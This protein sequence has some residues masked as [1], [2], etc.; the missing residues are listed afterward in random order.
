MPHLREASKALGRVNTLAAELKDPFI[1]SRILTWREAVSSSAIEGTNSTLDELLS[2][3][4]R[5]LEDVQAVTDATAQVR[6]YARL[7]ET[8]IPH[9]AD[10]GPEVFTV[11]LIR[12]LH[13]NVM[14]SDSAYQDEPGVL[15]KNVVWIGG[16]GNE[17]A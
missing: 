2:V 8:R 15:R 14:A 1:V 9:A 11:D 6:D 5:D 17:G 3:E 7:L 4:E 16:G 13:R 10:R 12:D